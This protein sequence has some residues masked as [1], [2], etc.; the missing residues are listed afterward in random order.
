MFEKP[1]PA[2][3]ATFN[4][5]AVDPIAT[6]AISLSSGGGAIDRRDT[7]RR[8]RRCYCRV[9]YIRAPYRTSENRRYL[10]VLIEIVALTRGSWGM[11]ILEIVFRRTK[12]SRMAFAYLK[13]DSI[14]RCSISFVV[15]AATERSQ[16]NV[17]DTRIN[18]NQRI[19]TMMRGICTAQGLL[20]IK[21]Q[22]SFDFRKI[23][24]I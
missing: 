15:V 23:T 17:P 13:G 5:I 9:I 11:C 10:R 18:I 22:I 2:F 1:P 14:R 20:S 3:P 21:S 7:A 24:I 16:R 4:V 12:T 19:Y 6:S 8:Q